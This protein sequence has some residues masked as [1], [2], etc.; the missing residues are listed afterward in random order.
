M[1]YRMIVHLDA[2]NKIKGIPQSLFHELKDHLSHLAEDPD[3]LS[4]S[5]V[6]PYSWAGP[7]SQFHADHG[8]TRHYFTIFFLFGPEDTEITI[9]DVTVNPKFKPP[10]S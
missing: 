8:S 7:I 4:R 10:E 9:M 3:S 5:S 6:F 1:P 2:F